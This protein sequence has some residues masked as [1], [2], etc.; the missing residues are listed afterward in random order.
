MIVIPRLELQSALCSN[1][2][3]S[4]LSPKCVS[5][6]VTITAIYNDL[7]STYSITNASV[8]IP[9]EL[10]LVQFGTFIMILALDC[11]HP[12]LLFITILE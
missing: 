8:S 9:L 10:L 2:A 4:N 3:Q 7:E 1:F 12:N 11:S 6:K 5:T